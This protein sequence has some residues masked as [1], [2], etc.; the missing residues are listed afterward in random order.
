MNIRKAKISDI[1]ELAKVHVDSWRTTYQGIISDD[2]LREL[3]YKKREEQWK[4]F[5]KKLSDKQF[6]YVAEDAMAGI[7][8]FII[9]GPERSDHPIYKGEL[10]GIY[11][12]REFQKKKLARY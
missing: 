4:G 8:G 12:L 5:L 11:L 10:W 6:I 2:F 3:S 7:V 9:G 1:P